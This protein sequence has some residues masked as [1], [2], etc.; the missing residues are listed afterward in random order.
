MG[1]MKNIANGA[2]KIMAG[3]KKAVKA[4][5][6][7]VKFIISPIGQIVGWIALIVF[8]VIIV[9]TVFKAAGKAIG[10]WLGYT[11]YYE[12]YDEDVL[13]IQELQNSGYSRQVDAK[14]FQNF[15]AF[16]YGVL[17]DAAEFLRNRINNG[18][19]DLLD[20]SYQYNQ[21]EGGYSGPYWDHVEEM[22][23][24]SSRANDLIALAG[25]RHP[26]K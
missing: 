18:K 20:V 11:N 7:G 22:A 3:I 25:F 17:M 14:N 6:N 13:V 4:I 9:V 19:L 1:V 5:V 26:R 12:T 23:K 8:A 10:E 2:K 24:S 16:E 15:K 21:G